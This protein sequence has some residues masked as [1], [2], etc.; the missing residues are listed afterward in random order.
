ML[1]LFTGQKEEV[2]RY[3]KPLIVAEKAGIKKCAL[4]G[5]SIGFMYLTVLTM[6]GLAFWYGAKLIVEDDYTVGQKLTVFIAVL[7]GAFG[8]SQLAQNAE[9]LAAAQTAAHTI[10]E[11]IDRVPPIDTQSNEGKILG[12][13]NVAP[14]SICS[15][16]VE[17]T[18]VHFT[19][20][21][22]EDQ[23]VLTDVSF[24]V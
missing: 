24:Q 4:T 5:A 17:F 10:Y 20:P 22:R 9:Y 7:L 11:I 12:K 23:E 19:Y 8:L 15:G 16:V 18:N 3:S 14:R 6:F 1:T 21:A 2:E 13:V